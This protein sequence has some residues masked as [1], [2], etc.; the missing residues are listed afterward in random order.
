[1]RWNPYSLSAAIVMVSAAGHVP[2]GEAPLALWYDRPAA[3]W[4][5]ALPRGNGRLAAMAFGKTDSERIQ[6]NEDTLWTGAPH[7]YTH[8]G[9]KDSLPAIRKL[10]F[11]GKQREAEALALESFMSVP[12]RQMAYQP[13]G[14]LWLD[15]GHAEVKSY[16]RE[17]DLQSAVAR[18]SYQSEGALFTREVFASF[19]DQVIVVRLE[20]DKPGRLS[21]TARLSTPIPSRA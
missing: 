7:D 11:E 13:F 8:A 14:D 19:P 9:A 2:A 10:L 3:E 5:E 20:C 12:L 16:R 18:V 15:F 6:F 17:L 4:T 1:M 21:F